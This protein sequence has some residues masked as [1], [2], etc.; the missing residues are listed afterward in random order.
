MEQRL[1]D[2]NNLK[3]TFEAAMTQA[4]ALY[5]K[6]DDIVVGPIMDMVLNTVVKVIDASPTVN[7]EPVRPGKWWRYP[8]E[9]LGFPEHVYMMRQCSECK[10]VFDQKWNYCPNCGAKM[11]N[12][13]EKDEE[14]EIW[15]SLKGNVEAPTGTFDKIYEDEDL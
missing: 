2:A 6:E 11:Y 13:K 12:V 4:K 3:L 8:L 15:H 7:A 1:I 10:K 14:T 5:L 9:Q